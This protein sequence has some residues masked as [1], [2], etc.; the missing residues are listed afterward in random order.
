V[1]THRV[2]NVEA[3]TFSID[4]QF[5]DGGKVVSVI[6]GRDRVVSSDTSLNYLRQFENKE[7][8]FA[9]GSSQPDSGLD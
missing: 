5:T 2:V 1:K 9:V 7:A 3:T 8:V 6:A 4:I